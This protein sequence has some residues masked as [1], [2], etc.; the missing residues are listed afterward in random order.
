[1]R[2]IYNIKIISYYLDR[3]G[4]KWAKNKAFFK[5]EQEKFCCYAVFAVLWFSIWKSSTKNSWK[6]TKPG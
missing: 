6:G 4:L 1:M 2:R 5:G 3:K